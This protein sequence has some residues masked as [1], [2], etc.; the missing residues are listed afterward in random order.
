[1][2][3]LAKP[4]TGLRLV[5]GFESLPLRSILI[6]LMALRARL[7]NLITESWSPSAKRVH[8]S[9]GPFAI[10]GWLPLSHAASICAAVRANPLGK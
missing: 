2:R 10:R 4:L 9:R 7:I 8:C 5:P 1:M 3:R 6:D